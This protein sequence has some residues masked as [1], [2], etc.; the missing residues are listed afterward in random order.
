MEAQDQIQLINDTINKTKDHLKESSFN[1]IFWGLLIAVLSFF[2]YVFPEIVQQ[3][4]YSILLYWVLIPVIGMIITVVYNIKK[5]VKV[6]YETYMGRTLKII[7]GVFNISWILLV[8][9]SFEKKIN[10]TESI[11]FLLGVMVLITGLLIRFKPLSFGGI[12]VIICSILCVYTPNNSWLLLNG[13]AA[14]LGLLIPGISLY[15]R[16]SNV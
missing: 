4:N 9:I 16:K 15:Y 2:H 6:G 12:S 1:F 8:F 13:I 11:L 5:R 7:W 3:T 14:V 10:P